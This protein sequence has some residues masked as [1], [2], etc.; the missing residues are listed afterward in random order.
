MG[1]RTGRKQPKEA[2]SGT[3]P[4]GHI[5]LAGLDFTTAVRAAL[6]TGKATPA[7]KKKVK[8]PD[9]KPALAKGH[10]AEDKKQRP[11]KGD[12][13][14]RIDEVLKDARE[15]AQQNRA[16]KPKPPPS[17][18]TWQSWKERAVSLRSKADLL[19]KA[20]DLTRARILR[21]DADAADASAEKAP[22]AP[23]RFYQR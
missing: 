6:A 11:R 12:L 14:K 18:R 22:D 5:S 2:M 8:A 7:P 19:E 13:Q 3:I 4:S 9:A 16:P 15:W 20:G 23:N 10:A 21:R 1:N 17:K